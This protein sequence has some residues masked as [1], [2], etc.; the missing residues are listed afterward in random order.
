MP[1]HDSSQCEVIDRLAEEFAARYRRGERPALQEYLDKYPELAEDIRAVFPAL[2]EMEQVKEDQAEPAASPAVAEKPPLRQVGD[3]RI[4]REVGRGAMGVVYEAEQV[5]L[6]R[7]VAV[8]VLAAHVAPDRQSLERFRREAKA[9]AK[10]HHTNIVPVFEVGQDGDTCYYAMQFIQGQSLDQIIE[11]LRRL[12]GHSLPNGERSLPETCATT[13]PAPGADAPRSGADALRPAVDQLAQSLLTGRFRIEGAAALVADGTEDRIAAPEAL[14]V[15]TTHADSSSL[16]ALPGQTDLSSVR[17]D[18]PHYFQSVARI[19]YQIA[20]ALA[21]AH[22]RKIIHR[23]IKPSNL[24]LDTAGV[25]WITDF[26]LAKT[27]EAALT[28]TGDIVGTLRYMSPE[29]FRGEGDERSDVYALGLTLY[30]ML[31]LRPAFDAR[32]RLQLIDRIKNQEPPRPRL[33]D[34]RIPRDLETIVL[35]AIHK[36]ATQRY[37]TAEAMAEDLRRFLADEPIKA[38]RTSNLA[39]LRLW[40]RRHPALAALLLLL[41]L[42][43]AGATATAFHLRAMLAETEEA[44]LKERMAKIQAE[45][46]RDQAKEAEQRAEKGQERAL[47]AKRKARLREA[48]ALVGQAH[49]T[50]LSRRPGQRF[51]ALD[52]LGKAVA[53]GREL[54]QPP[55]WFDRLRNEA[56]AALALPDIHI[57]KEFDGFPPGTV[58]VDLS[59]DFELYVRSTE[60]GLC[61]IHRV[62]NNAEIARLPEFDERAEASFGSGRILAVRGSSGRFQLW[63]LSGAEPVRRFQKDGIYGSCFRPDGCLLALCHNDGS[64]SVHDVAAGQRTYHLPPGEIVRGLSLALHPSEPFVACFSYHYHPVLVRDLRT[65]AVAAS[66]NPPWRGNGNCAW[67][68]D[69]RTLTVPDGDSGAIQ[70]WAFDPTAPAL[71]LLRTIQGPHNGG[72]CLSYNP[73]GDRF[74]TRGWDGV[75]H[76]FDAISGQWLFSTHSLPKNVV[77]GGAYLRFDRT[78]QRLAAARVGNHQERVGLWSVADAREYRALVPSRRVSAWGKPAIHPGGRLA[79]IGVMDG[80]VLFD[81]ETGRELAKWPALHRG[82]GGAG[83]AL[84]GAG[85][86][87]TNDF[88]GL[89]R[90]PVKQDPAN[91]DRLIIGPP[92]RLPFY[93]GEKQ[94][95]TSRDGRVIAQCMWNGY[96]MDKYAGG[97]ILHPNSL[98]PRRVRA[99]LSTG[100]CSVSPDGRWVAFGGETVDV[101]DAATGKRVWQSPREHNH[102][103]FSPDGR[104]LATDGDGG[105]LYATGTWEPGPSCGPGTPCDISPDSTLAILAQT[106]GIYRLVELAT[107]RELARLEDPEQN[108]GAAV[109]APDG[110][111]LIVAAKNGLRVWDLRRIRAELAKL[112]LDWDAPPYLPIKEKKNPSPLEVTVDLGLLLPAEPP[113]QAIIKYSLALSVMPINP[114]AYLRRGHAYYQ[115]RQWR[116]AAD[117]L[118]LALTLDPGN[119]DVQAWS[120]LASACHGSLRLKEAVAAYSRVIQLE[121]DNVNA[122]NGRGVAYYNLGL[123]D[124]ALADLDK[125]LKLQADSPFVNNNLAW[126]L[127]TCPQA[128]LRDRV[129]A[130]DLAKQAVALQPK[131]RTCWTTLGV[132]QY[133]AGDWSAARDALRKS[134]ELRQGKENGFWYGRTALFLAMS[135]WQLGE[136]EKARDSYRQALEWMQ[137]N[138]PALEKDQGRWQELRRF[139]SEAESVLAQPP[140]RAK[141]K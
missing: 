40:S 74:V 43:A 127:A 119:H 118:G 96:G 57:T 77:G 69:G 19:G 94:I 45:L 101:F 123:W 121:P 51:E 9:A 31:V 22:A 44:H 115:L 80:V 6:G 75:V 82:S 139:R 103:R 104:W 58:R 65:G 24:L 21:Y 66:I 105:H 97:W 133:R 120:E 79:A 5:S 110:T 14:D 47:K 73:A 64:I 20:H 100:C 107:G 59:D 29:R 13:C 25:V 99:G 11:E 27:Q 15:S 12:R 111:K 131:E 56:I 1:T 83:I 76:L 41:A 117:D 108:T 10:L 3:Y 93:P 70:Q 140:S 23:D 78:G 39:R 8:K 34:R 68:P 63:D 87:L 72:P 26:G 136:K 89:F 90:W 92:K 125:A 141:K 106:N 32:D 85:N 37:Q 67:S 35:K 46:A 62:A 86:L 81:L 61:T 4:L 60:K 36:E 16:A 122:Y 112:G 91:R 84:D 138:K 53:L 50:R 132:A 54:G 129:R 88:A 18:R 28:T 124:K 109:F 17:T 38:K 126:Q 30:E 114:V 116:Q 49:G 128:R 71:R 2:V 33:L 113:Q 7:R 130:V 95:S 55:E 134:L 135:H 98:A 137:K 102:C 42:V 52:A 48:D